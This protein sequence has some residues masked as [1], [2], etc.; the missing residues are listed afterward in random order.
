MKKQVSIFTFGCKLNQYETET[1]REKLSYKYDVSVEGEKANLFIINTCTVTSEAE[2]KTRQL[3][4]KLKRENDRASFVA[5]GCYS[6]LSPEDF[7]SLGFDY[8][9]GIDEKGSI[10]TI[11]DTVFNGEEPVIKKENN[12][13][14][15]DKG[16]ADR[17][18]AYLA[19][20]DGCLNNCAYC[21]IRLARGNRIQSKDRD[22][23]LDEFKNLLKNGYREIVLTGVNIGYYGFDTNDNLLGLLR[24]L[25]IVHGNWRLRLSSIDPRIVSDELID[26]IA[27]HEK[28]AQHLHL[29]LQSGSNDI[30]MRMKRGYTTERYETI[31]EKLRIRNERFSFTTDIIVGFPGE[32]N[33]EFEETCS[34]V[35]KR[36]FLK[37]HIFRFSPRP[38][39]EAFTMKDRISGTIKKN[40]ARLLRDIAEK[41]SRSYLKSQEGKR[42]TVLVENTYDGYSFGYDEYYIQHRI[43]GKYT[44]GFVEVH[45]LTTGRSEAFSNAELC[46]ESV[47]V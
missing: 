4:R 20:Q 24:C 16:L 22:L 30:L 5:V 35:R 26:Y 39:T 1:M 46:C 45:I 31:V 12:I 14:I 21:R 43:N 41:G 17:T 33:E 8:V 9:G 15:A 32:T 2:R 18:R 23:V 47:E 19:I 36:E 42:S 13:L 38:G 27:N 7:E 44:E 40:R 6:K 3:Y 37:V 11:V 10:D 25:S 29:S 28:I 34:F